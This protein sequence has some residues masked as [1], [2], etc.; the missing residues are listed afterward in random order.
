MHCVDVVCDE[1]EKDLIRHEYLTKGKEAS[2][3]NLKSLQQNEKR[4]KVNQMSEV[5]FADK[6]VALMTDNTT[7][8][9]IMNAKTAA[10]KAGLSAGIICF[11]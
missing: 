9:N 5:T 6:M 7:D 3:D 4:L 2:Q 10:C 1:C 8:K 11:G